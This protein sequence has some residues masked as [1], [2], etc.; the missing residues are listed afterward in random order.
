MAKKKSKKKQPV[1]PCRDTNQHVRESA[2]ERARVAAARQKRY[3]KI[4]EEYLEE[5]KRRETMKKPIASPTVTP[6]ES[7]RD[8]ANE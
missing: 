4:R 3:E 7:G 1:V 2:M 8:A 5:M 6:P